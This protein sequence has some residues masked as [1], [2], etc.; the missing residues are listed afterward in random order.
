MTEGIWG[1]GGVVLGAVLT[2]FL[3]LF[4]D[5]WMAAQI[6]KKQAHY[7]AVCVVCVLDKY[8][9]SCAD[10][11]CDGE[12]DLDEYGAYVC[13]VKDPQKPSY[14]EDIDWRS[15]DADLVYRILEFPKR[16]RCS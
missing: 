6:R 2:T 8:I 3:T 7:L 9:E 13:E 1:L 10:V 5:W 14:A 4:K 16:N 11:A 15:I 12:G